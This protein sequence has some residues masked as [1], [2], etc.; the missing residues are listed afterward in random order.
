LEA[1]LPWITTP[2][3][4]KLQVYLFNQSFYSI[5]HLLQFMGSAKNLRLKTTTFSFDIDCLIVTASPHEEAR[6]YTFQMELGGRNF[7]RQVASAGQVFHALREVFSVTEHL[8]LEYRR[9]GIS[10]EWNNE[11][12]HTLW[13]ELLRSFGNAKTLRV[14][15]RLVEQ[16]SRA[17]QPGEGESPM[18][19]LPR[20]REI[21]CSAVGAARDAFTPFIDAR[22]NAGD[23]VT[24]VLLRKIHS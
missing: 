11:A 7:D 1:L 13:R 17:L 23:P 9:H 15:S 2:L 6:R 5:P 3:L 18:E 22:Q 8:T 12:H 4:E 14:N 21:S 24:L 10:S 19:L 20:L 16:V